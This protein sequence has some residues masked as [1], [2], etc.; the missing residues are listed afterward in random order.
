MTSLAHAQ[1]M[2]A[3]NRCLW[4]AVTHPGVTNLIWLPGLVGVAEARGA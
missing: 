4:S 2:A 1:T 3:Y